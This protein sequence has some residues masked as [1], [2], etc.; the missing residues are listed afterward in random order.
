MSSSRVFGS[1]QHYVGHAD[2]SIVLP[3]EFE[4]KKRVVLPCPVCSLQ[5]QVRERERE[6]QRQRY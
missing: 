6:R 5:I 2:A 1:F 3:E 4:E